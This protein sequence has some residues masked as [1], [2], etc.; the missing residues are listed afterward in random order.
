MSQLDTTYTEVE[1]RELRHLCKNA[2]QTLVGTAGALMDFRH[3]L[4]PFY[5]V[6]F[7]NRH[8]AWAAISGAERHRGTPDIKSM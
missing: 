8:P 2:S 1:S 5:Y 7:K 4:Q 6:A 3:P